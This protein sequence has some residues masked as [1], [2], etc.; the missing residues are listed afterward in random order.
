[1]DIRTQLALI[2]CL[3][4]LVGYVAFLFYKS[5]CSDLECC[6]NFKSHRNTD[7]EDPNV[8]PFSISLPNAV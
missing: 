6:L 3:C 7:Q 4:L 2:V 8:K 5:K 1:M